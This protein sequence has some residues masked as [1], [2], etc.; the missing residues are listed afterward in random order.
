MK[1]YTVT[2][3]IRAEN[4]GDAKALAA[5]AALAVPTD[6]FDVARGKRGYNAIHLDPDA[7]REHYEDGLEDDEYAPTHGLSDEQIL[8]AVTAL[9]FTSDYLWGTVW[10]ALTGELED[11]KNYPEEGDNE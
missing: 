11:V 9:L 10:D 5:I 7:V 4:E 8:K 2:L 6:H 3:S 1:D